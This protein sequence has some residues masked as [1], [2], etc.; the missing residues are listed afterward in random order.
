M[1]AISC[2]NEWNEDCWHSDIFW[3]I[4]APRPGN[5]GQFQA[6][7]FWDLECFNFSIS[8]SSKIPFTTCVNIKSAQNIPKTISGGSSQNLVMNATKLAARLT[9]MGRT[10]QLSEPY[11]SLLKMPRL[12]VSLQTSGLLHAFPL[13]SE[14]SVVWKTTRPCYFRSSFK[15]LVGFST[16]SN[17]GTFYEA[18]NSKILIPV[19]TINGLPSQLLL[20]SK[21]PK[22]LSFLYVPY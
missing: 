3:P 21:K 9:N 22:S 17:V 8:R 20:C 13:L 18:A 5:I 11:G 4:G 7:A 15:L 2:S 12:W 10:A 14:C 6:W 1:Y 16:L 19:H